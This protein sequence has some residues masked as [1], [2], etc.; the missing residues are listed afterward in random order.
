LSIETHGN[1]GGPR[2]APPERDGLVLGATT[3]D[4]EKLYRAE[5][6][7]GTATG[8]FVTSIDLCGRATVVP[9]AIMLTFSA[10]ASVV[11]SVE[12]AGLPTILHVPYYWQDNL[13][14]CMPTSLAM[15]MN[16]FD[17]L[18]GIVSN[19]EL[20]GADGQGPQDFNKY[21]ALLGSMGVAASV[22]SGKNWDVDLIS[23]TPFY[24]YVKTVLSGTYPQYT[25]GLAMSSTTTSHG[26]V[27]VGANND[28]IWL[29]DPSGAFVPGPAAIAVKLTWAE[30][31]AIA[32]DP[33]STGDVKTLYINKPL[34][35][36]EQLTGSIVL[37][38]GAGG[39]W[40][41]ETD[42]GVAI[43]H[44]IWDGAISPYGYYWDDPQNNLP[45]Y[46][47]YSHRFPRSGT[48]SHL[49]GRFAY[50]FRVAN[51]TGTERSYQVYIFLENQLGTVLDS[52]L[53]DVSAPRYTWDTG[54]TGVLD[55]FN[56]VA[57][58]EYQ[59]K[60]ELW[61]AGNWLDVKRVGFQVGDGPLAI[62]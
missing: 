54:V 49:P 52:K 60:V 61:E 8:S 27:G 42:A 17:D 16:Q 57:D 4:G 25:R 6:T 46:P 38:P 53:V 11:H 9:G 21:T 13:T 32:V 7:P 36:A 23:S 31:N 33:N 1:G 58:G 29:H 47:F 2:G 45:I 56:I 22:Y 10:H 30:F 43:S 14:W 44:W 26:F 15:V 37:D 59:L 3:S 34:R 55:N 12:L 19:Y 5:V 20:A 50:D 41:Y 62:P 40:T 28:Y 35:P 48:P 39:S 51:V 18:A 24:N